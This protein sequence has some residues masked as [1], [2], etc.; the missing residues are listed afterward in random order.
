MKILTFLS[1][2]FLLISCLSLLEADSEQ[3]PASITRVDVWEL[4]E[5]HG[6]NSLRLLYDHAINK[7]LPDHIR[8]LAASILIES[9]I[10]PIVVF[11]WKG[12]D[13]FNESDILKFFE[14]HSKSEVVLL[15]RSTLENKREIVYEIRNK[16]FELI[17][18]KKDFEEVRQDD[19]RNLTLQ[20]LYKAIY[21]TIE[22]YELLEEMP[23]H[24]INLH[25]DRHTLRWFVVVQFFFVDKRMGLLALLDSTTAVFGEE[26]EGP[27]E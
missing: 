4:A 7:S 15:Y 6:E 26:F 2:G 20:E 19:L 13:A 14:E 11:K 21:E 25:H 5:R 27:S 22:G 24:S 8:A 1:L 23:I 18:R 10:G 16:D 9:Y 17:I 3:K 12:E